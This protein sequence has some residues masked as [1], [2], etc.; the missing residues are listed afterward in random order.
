MS[1]GPPKR[2]P[3][4]PYQRVRSRIAARRAKR[5]RG[6]ALIMVLGALVVLT[7]LVTDLTE[8]STSTLSAALADRD[9]IRAE[10]HAKSAFNL[11]RLLIASE[12]TI[13]RALAGPLAILTR[14]KP[15]PQIPVWKFTDKVLGAFN[16]GDSALEFQR[17]AGT[18]P[19]TGKNLGIEGGSFVVKVVDED[20][21]INVNLGARGD[22]ISRNRLGAQLLG[23]MGPPQYNEMFEA[24]DLDGQISSR[25]AICG[26]IVDW[27][28]PDETHYPCDPFATSASG[29]GGPEDN[30]Y[31]QV[32]LSYLRRN[33]AF[34][35]LEE[36][37]LVRGVSDDF[38]A[39]FVDPDPAN[40]DQ[41][42]L[43]VWGRDQVNIQSASPLTMLGI[44]CA[45]APES[46]VC[47]DPMQTQSFVMGVTLL[48]SIMPM[49]PMTPKQFV[50][51]LRG[52][53]QIGQILAS[54]GIEPV[55]FSSPK[56]VERMLTNQSK[57]FSI[58]VDGVVPGRK[59]ETRVRLH[60]VVDFRNAAEIGETQAGLA[61]LL[62]GQDG[63]A[64]QAASTGEVAPEELAAALASD[65]MG[66]IIYYRLE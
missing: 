45:G 40:P 9:S 62:L 4:T 47:I 22:P 11:T 3:S 24:A 13:R 32:G 53:G 1:A 57:I 58:Y 2:A 10:Y 64:S 16:S 31:Q 25:Q 63:T 17:L 30:F 35:S 43:T 23:L 29:S 15:P 56:E 14:G 55:T 60:G 6:V 51:A 37:R 54:V 19:E 39:T 20:S 49:L 27:A 18:N 34:S 33:A 48:K 36:L 66:A 65:P 5:K 8:Q 12:P 42:S 7:V 38:W 44:V 41:R 26:A 28:D 46:G 52:R 21:K 59:R 61:G 50:S